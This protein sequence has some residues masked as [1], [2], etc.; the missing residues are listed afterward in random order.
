[1]AGPVHKVLLFLAIPICIDRIID[2][3]TIRTLSLTNFF[4][5]LNQKLWCNRNKFG[6][7]WIAYAWQDCVIRSKLVDICKLQVANSL[8][9]EVNDLTAAELPEKMLS[10]ENLLNFMAFLKGFW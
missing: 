5:E 4:K 1:M 8:S 2:P 6:R 3:H 10:S 7:V 9:L